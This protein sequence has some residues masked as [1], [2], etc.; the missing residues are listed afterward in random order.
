[1]AAAQALLF[2]GQGSHA[3]G[4]GAPHRGARLFERGLELLGFDPFEQLD[5]G[6]RTQQP[7][8]V[9]CS[10]AAW[11]EAGRPEAAAA[12][13]HSLG[14]YAALVAAGALAFDDAARLVAVSG[15]A[16]ASRA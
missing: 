1:M 10:V 13:E 6:T 9:L 11:D 15:Q 7:A 3:H 4:M 2:P 5:A 8:L 12:G 16:M 14:E